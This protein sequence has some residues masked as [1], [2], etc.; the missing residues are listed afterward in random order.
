MKFLLA[1]FLLAVCSLGESKKPKAQ[2]VIYVQKV[3]P[4]QKQLSE[5]DL[6]KEQCRIES[7][8]QS[9]KERVELLKQ[10]IDR[11]EQLLA[12]HNKHVDAPEIA[13]ETYME[14]GQVPPM[15]KASRYDHLKMA[16]NK[17]VESTSELKNAVTGGGDN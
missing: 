5:Y 11:A 9:N 14:A 2:K 13:P 10:E 12:E 1:V 4:P 7:E 6:C 16:A 15:R 3:V 8:T 17:I